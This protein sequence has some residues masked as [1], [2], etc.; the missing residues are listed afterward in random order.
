MSAIVGDDVCHEC[1]D[2][3]RL[4]EGAHACLLSVQREV[5][6]CLACDASPRREGWG[7]WSTTVSAPS[8]F[9]TAL[10]PFRLRSSLPSV[11][12]SHVA[13]SA[14]RGSAPFLLPSPPF[15]TTPCTHGGSRMFLRSPSDVP[16]DVVAHLTSSQDTVPATTSSTHLPRSSGLSEPTASVPW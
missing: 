9:L 16:T 15:L 8:S 3:V 12:R 14:V 11:L 5:G 6:R 10:V 13:C 4:R 1:G 7:E 2:L